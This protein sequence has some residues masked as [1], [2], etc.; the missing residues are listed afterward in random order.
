MLLRKRAEEILDLVEK[1]ES[2][3][4]APRES[5][6]GDIHIGS[7]ETYIISLLSNVIKDIR[8]EYPG[9]SFHFFS[10]NADDVMERLDKGLIDFGVLIGPSNIARYDSIRLPD[11][12]TWG[13]LMQKEHPLAGKD[14]IRAS[15]LIGI[16]LICSGQ[17]SS[18]DLFT[19]WLQGDYEKLNIAATYTLLYNAALLVKAGVGCS[20]CLDRI[21]S[22]SEDSGLCFR[23]LEPKLE[24]RWHIVR[25]RH[26]IFSNASEY[27]L[28]KVQ[29]VFAEAQGDGDE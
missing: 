26:Q 7:G 25:K 16:P 13:L 14:V 29:E 10:G 19:K 20:L 28:K 3:L 21:V 23:P 1:A 4:T 6:S 8:D 22:T 27:F 17:R 18:S 15:D 5:I 24:A 9:I 2:E 11:A 12:D